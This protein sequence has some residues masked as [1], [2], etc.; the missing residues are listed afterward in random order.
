M[1]TLLSGTWVALMFGALSAVS[2]P[3][4]NP[5]DLDFV[6]IG[7]PNNPADSNGCGKVGYAYRITRQPIDNQTYVRFLN[8]AD[9]G[10]TNTKNLYNPKMMLSP[11]GGITFNNRAPEGQKYEAKPGA[12]RN[13]VA[14]VNWS[15][16]ARFSNW[17]SNGAQKG[18]STEIGAY[19]LRN[20]KGGLAERSNNSRYCIPTQNELYKA[21]FYLPSGAG[22][23][24]ENQLYVN[25]TGSLIPSELG[26]I[27]LPIVNGVVGELVDPYDVKPSGPQWTVDNQG[28][29]S[30]FQFSGKND[31][32]VENDSVGFR[33]ASMDSQYAEERDD[34]EEYAG[35][36]DLTSTSFSP[37]FPLPASNSGTGSS[38]AAVAASFDLPPSS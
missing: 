12:A 5:G 21:A 29:P 26:A 17:L 32:F 9:P 22:R 15:D 33:L 27:S 7:S 23:T 37:S 8:S 19:N 10:G 30:F 35:A 14:F 16:A 34:V 31:P 38:Q 6:S 11:Q 3:I 18:S 4:S 2:A 24:N 36:P 20:S 25:L 28:S 13:P 1:K